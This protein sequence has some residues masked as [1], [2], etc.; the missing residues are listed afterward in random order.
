MSDDLICIP[1]ILIELP[2]TCHLHIEGA[3]VASIL[4]GGH[5]RHLSNVSTL[6]FQQLQRVLVI[7]W[8]CHLI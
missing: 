4:I 2:P 3:A 8:H 5:K 7:I 6:H 1:S